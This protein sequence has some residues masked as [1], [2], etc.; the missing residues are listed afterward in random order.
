M[1]WI[2]RPARLSGPNLTW[3]IQPWWLQRLHFEEGYLYPSL[4]SS[5]S[6][7][8]SSRTRHYL[9]PTSLLDLHLQPPKVP[10]LWRIEGGGPNLH[11]HQRNF[12]FPIHLLEGFIPSGSLETIGG[13]IRDF[14]CLCGFLASMAF[15]GASN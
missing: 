2:I 14:C 10:D 4:S 5:P 8:S 1:G 7:S 9:E 11:L 15:L 6:C 3:I 13:V 12:F